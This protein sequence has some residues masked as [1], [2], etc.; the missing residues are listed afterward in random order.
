MTDPAANTIRFDDGAA[1]ERYMGVWSRLVGESFLRWLA[2]PPGWRWLDVGCGNGAFTEMLADR[3]Q[4]SA[5]AGIDPS[6][7]QLAYARQRPALVGADFRQ[8]DAM[9]MPFADASFDA[10]VMP[11]VIFFVP[12]P[13]RG[14]G[15]MARVVRPGG[16]VAAYAWDMDHGG[17]PYTALIEEMAALGVE[18]PK[19]PSTEAARLDVLESLWSG[20]GLTDVATTVID[21]ERAWPSFDDYWATV[22]GS[23]SASGRLK[24]MP[25]ADRQVVATRLRQRLAGPDGAVRYHARAH[26]VRGRLR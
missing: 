25:D 10:A 2:P 14:V 21:V 23:P 26:A 17:F 11:L 4:P 12:D 15:E 1:Y 6:K 9:R 7:A 8:A 3:V 18:V 13:A 20:A 24:G 5:L 19:A 22:L 16:L